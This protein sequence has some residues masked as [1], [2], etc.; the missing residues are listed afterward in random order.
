MSTT[1]PIFTAGGLASGLDTNTIVDKLV[2]LEAA[3][4]T[5]NNARQAA[6]NV[7]ISSIGDLLSKIKS[8]ASTASTLGK[9]VV[10]NSVTTVP[11]GIAAVAGTGAMPGQYSI[12][13]S[14]VASLAKARS[15]AVFTSANDTVAGGTL[16]LHIQGVATTIPIAAN[17]DLGSVASQINQA[18]KAIS[19]AVISDGSHYYLSLTNRDTGKPLG[20]GI[21]GGLSI[22]SDTTG[23]GMAVTR[24]ATNA[25]LN[26]DGLDVESKTNDISTAVP[27]VTLTV[28]AEQP[29]ASDLVISADS[30]KSTDNLQSFV[31]SYNS[32]IGVLQQSLRPDPN[33]PPARGSTLDGTTVLTLQQKMHGLLSSQVVG[34]GSVRTLADIGVKLQNDGTLVVDQPLFAKSMAKDP[35]A[36]DAIFS[37]ASTGMAAKVAALSTSFTD[38]L[39]GQ[40]VQRRTSLNKTIKDLVASNVQLQNHVDTY[41]LQLQRSFT[42]M[43]GLIANYNSISTFLNANSGTTT[44]SGKK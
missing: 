14:S 10:A 30:S 18:G 20:S 39:D 19:A 24:N 32:I 23:L 38:P 25:K 21:D 41:K 8:L 6:L 16:S 34:T 33:A 7:Q 11:A 37:T 36:V 43:E 15:T 1:T 27:G 3:P 29:V 31:D 44:T 5:T 35:T 9:G 42:T 22:D 26:M 17:S 40:L 2:A 12:S 13:V 28:K 4:I